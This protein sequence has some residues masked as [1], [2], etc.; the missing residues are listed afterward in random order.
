MYMYI[1]A[2]CVHI[3]MLTFMVL[4]FVE[5]NHSTK[6]AK[7]NN[8]EISIYKVDIMLLFLCFTTAEL[9]G[10]KQEAAR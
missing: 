9:G 3:C 6:T 7:M 5:I 8:L 10:V 1:Y 4:I 2:H